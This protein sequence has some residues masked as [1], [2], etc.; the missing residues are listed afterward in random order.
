MQ[1]FSA[2]FLLQ[3]FLDFLMKR[4]GL[5]GSKFRVFIQM[6]RSTEVQRTG[7]SSFFTELFACSGGNFQSAVKECR[8]A[9]A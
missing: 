6:Q 9:K 4:D 2:V 1:L 3:D 7:V 5:L 8:I